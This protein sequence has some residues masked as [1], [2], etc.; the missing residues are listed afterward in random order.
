MKGKW[1]GAKCMGVAFF[2]FLVAYQRGLQLRR[3]HLSKD[4]KRQGLHLVN[5]QKKS[6]LGREHVKPL[7]KERPGVLEEK[8]QD[9]CN[10]SWWHMDQSCN[11][12][13]ECIEPGEPLR[14]PD[15]FSFECYGKALEIFEQM[16]V[17]WSDFHLKGITLSAVLTIDRKRATVKVRRMIGRTLQ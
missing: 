4:P 17:S 16:S 5:I 2:F 8:E 12:G 1:G 13:P 3:W 6:I 7:K 9:C 11:R 10:W 15:F 14:G